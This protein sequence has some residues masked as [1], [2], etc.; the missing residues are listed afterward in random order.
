VGDYDETKYSEFALDFL[1]KNKLKIIRGNEA[2][3]QYIKRQ[4]LLRIQ[5][6]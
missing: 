3:K 5:T 4:K 2:I 1:K 6:V